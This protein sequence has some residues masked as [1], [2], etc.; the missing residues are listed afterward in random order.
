M[1]IISSE[2]TE[3]KLSPFADFFPFLLNQWK[4]I[5]TNTHKTLEHLICFL[6]SCAPISLKFISNALM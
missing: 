1:I 5:T 6:I 3:K 4:W 2:N